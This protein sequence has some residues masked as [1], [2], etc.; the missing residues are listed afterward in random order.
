[1]GGFFRWLLNVV[2]ERRTIIT[3]RG[4]AEMRGRVKKEREVS[5][6]EVCEVLKKLKMGKAPGTY[7]LCGNMLK[8]WWRNSSEVDMENVLL[9]PGMGGED[10]AS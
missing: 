1:M 10:N 7:E 2:N 9:L 6:A 5:R 4:M 8:V 3:A